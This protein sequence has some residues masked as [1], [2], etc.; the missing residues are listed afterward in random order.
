MGAT[1]GNLGNLN[2]VLASIDIACL[3]GLDI[4]SHDGRSQRTR[5]IAKEQ[6]RIVGILLQTAECTRDR[7][8]ADIQT[9]L[10]SAISVHKILKY[11]TIGIQLTQLLLFYGKD[12]VGV[13]V[14]SL[15]SDIECRLRN[16]ADCHLKLILRRGNGVNLKPLIRDLTKWL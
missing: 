9:Q 6:H 3:S 4:L 10:R 2:N 1:I 5:L 11:C 7:A 12:G 14:G 16:I 8:V 13:F 15:N